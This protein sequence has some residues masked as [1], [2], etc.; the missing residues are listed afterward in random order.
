MCLCT[1]VT[2]EGGLGESPAVH[3]AAGVSHTSNQDHASPRCLYASYSFQ[4]A[5]LKG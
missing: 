2:L 3:G 4:V 1:E 5:S